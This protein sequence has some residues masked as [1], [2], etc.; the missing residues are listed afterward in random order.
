M[1]PLPRGKGGEENAAAERG[2]AEAGAVD[3]A[4]TAQTITTTGVVGT[5]CAAKSMTAAPAE[6]ASSAAATN[7]TTATLTAAGMAEVA[8]TADMAMAIVSV[9]SETDTIA[10]P[11]TADPATTST[12]AEILVDCPHLVVAESGARIPTGTPV[13]DHAAAALVLLPTTSATTGA[14]EEKQESTTTAAATTAERCVVRFSS[15]DV[16]LRERSRSQGSR[17]DS[18]TITKRRVRPGVKKLQRPEGF[19][20]S[21]ADKE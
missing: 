21:M 11:V 3:M 2:A 18:T 9:T 10:K 4:M 1:A 16:R 19:N 14:Q 6:A 13:P 17:R 5:E 8:G 7:G 20:V 12:P 15:T